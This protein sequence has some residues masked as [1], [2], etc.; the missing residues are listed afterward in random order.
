MIFGGEADPQMELAL[1]EV[2]EAV[3][4]KDLVWNISIVQDF[5]ATRRMVNVLT[6]LKPDVVHTHQ[7]KAGVVGR[8]AAKLA[9]VPVI[10]H[11]VHI[12][13]FVGE[14][15]VKRTMYILAERLLSSVTDAYINVSSGVRDVGIEHRIGSERKHFVA[16]SGMPIE[17]FR[18]A[19]PPSDWRAIVG[20]G[21]HDARPPVILMLAAL[22]ARKRHF[23]FLKA[24]RKVVSRVPDIRVILAGQGPE[25]PRLRQLVRDEDMEGNVRFVG[26]YPEPERLIAMSDFTVLTS[27]REGL[28]RVTIQ[29]LAGG[30]PVVMMRLPG[31]EDIL[32]DGENSI[33]VDPGDFEAMASEV[34]GLVEDEDRLRRMQAAAAATRVDSWSVDAMTGKIAEI[35]TAVG[36]PYRREA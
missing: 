20:V 26:F 22:E 24:F 5:K 31:L 14:R 15:P 23:Q 32:V 36:A 27:A 11:G 19:S 25:L 35:Y 21:E 10:I 12:L 16:H 30:R 33:L 7:S 9:G 3:Q 34:A 29:S 1:R 2:A 4:I 6:G 28:P 13:P 8:L 18:H 17:R